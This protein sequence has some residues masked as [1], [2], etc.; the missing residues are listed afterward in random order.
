MMTPSAKKGDVVQLWHV[1][2]AEGKILGRFASEVARILRGKHKPF[3]TPHIDTGDH[4][5]IVNA[6]KIQVKGNNKAK[7]KVYT[8]YSGYPGGL[9]KQT[10]EDALAE[11]PSFVLE[12]A[13]RGMLPHTKL[14]RQMMKKVKI[15]A[16]PDHPHQA[17][18]P[19]PINL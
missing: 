15:Y 10:L 13:I 17:Q 14:G 12:H 9:K 8:R 3:Y 19:E 1:A 4:V 2:D 7:Q 11:R 6:E 18:S 16:G 5:V